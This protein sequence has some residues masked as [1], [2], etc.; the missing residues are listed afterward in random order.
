MSLASSQKLFDATVTETVAAD[1]V[2]VGNGVGLQLPAGVLRGLLIINEAPYLG[3][4]TGTPAIKYAIG[5][6]SNADADLT[7]PTDVDVMIDSGDKTA[8]GVHGDQASDHVAAYFPMDNH[9]A[10]LASA[11]TLYLN[12]LIK[13]SAPDFGAGTVKCALKV[14]ALMDSVE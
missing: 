13:S 1:G 2:Y 12:Y 11:T 14:V 8:A 7:D 4:A 5:T 6:A 3:T 10:Y 9:G